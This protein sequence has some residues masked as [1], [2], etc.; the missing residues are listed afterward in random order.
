MGVTE[1][2]VC[3][4]ATRRDSVASNHQSQEVPGSPPD[5]SVRQ[6][7]LS[8]LAPRLTEALV[9]LWFDCSLFEGQA[10][11]G[12]LSLRGCTGGGLVL[13]PHCKTSV[14]SSFS[15]TPC[16]CPPSQPYPAVHVS[17]LTSG[18]YPARKSPGSPGGWHS[19]STP[20]AG[21]P[22]RCP[23]PPRTPPG[24]SSC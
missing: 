9:S 17:V 16:L 4:K 14:S 15:S 12:A 7:D 5:L 20:G 1:S 3:R 19:P 8:P 2:R 23:R 10:L 13:V 24:S 18:D 6:S 21:P 11:F 22:R